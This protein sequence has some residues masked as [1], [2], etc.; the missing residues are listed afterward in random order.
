MSNDVTAGYIIVDVERLRKPMQ[1]IT[2]YIL[3]CME[4]IESADVINIQTAS[5]DQIKKPL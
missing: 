2:D 1:L 3:K 4:V 5:K